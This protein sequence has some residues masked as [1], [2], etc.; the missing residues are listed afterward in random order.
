MSRLMSLSFRNAFKSPLLYLSGLAMSAFFFVLLLFLSL[1]FHIPEAYAHTLDYLEYGTSSFAIGRYITPEEVKTLWKDTDIDFTLSLENADSSPVS[2]DIFLSL[3]QGAVVSGFHFSA[4]TPL[5]REEEQAFESG[6]FVSG[7]IQ[8]DKEDSYALVIEEDAM[9]ACQISIGDTISLYPPQGKEPVSFFISGVL[10]GSSSDNPNYFHV[11]LS[12]DAFRKVQEI[13]YK[14]PLSYAFRAELQGKEEIRKAVEETTQLGY[15]FLCPDYSVILANDQTIAALKVV[16]LSIAILI[17]FFAFLLEVLLSI[18][19][20]DNHLKSLA[21]YHAMGCPLFHL[22]LLLEVLPFLAFLLSLI[23]ALPSYFLV[24]DYLA[25]LFSSIFLTP[26]SLTLP[27]YGVL[28]LVFFSLLL[29]LL[30]F[31]FLRH[32]LSKARLFSSLKSEGE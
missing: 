1:T 31:L 29:L 10:S 28:L 6:D 4:T 27:P 11:Y 15:P 21:L 26:I 19:L 17:F 20:L 9:S 24:R 2:D 32:R 16:F 3:E 8:P 12:Q 22:A 7:G 5:T 18:R 23:I 25:S 13:V 30:S 14:E